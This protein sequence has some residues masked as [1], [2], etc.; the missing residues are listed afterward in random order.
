MRIETSNF[1]FFAK[2]DG[3]AQ[4]FFRPSCLDPLDIDERLI[5]DPQ[6]K[7]EALARYFATKLSANGT[8]G[9]ASN[10]LVRRAIRERYKGGTG[11]LEP[12]VGRDEILLA[13]ADLPV[14]RAP[15]PDQLPAE[16]FKHLPAFL[17]VLPGM[18]THMIETNQNV[19]QL[20]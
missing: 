14:N 2:K 5:I 1:Q 19:F 18:Y 9:S 13:A 12:P 7:A 11:L 8:P 20:R 4:P 17:D 16:V 3:R 10:T 15:G 6:L